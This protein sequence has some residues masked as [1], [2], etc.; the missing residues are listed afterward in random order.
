MDMDLNPENAHFKFSTDAN[1][2]YDIGIACLKSSSLSVSGTEVE[3]VIPNK[4]SSIQSDSVIR[5]QQTEASRHTKTKST[6][7][8][9]EEP[10]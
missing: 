9:D 1:I 6:F 5:K 2:V 4:T 10:I 8:D 7:P 3:E